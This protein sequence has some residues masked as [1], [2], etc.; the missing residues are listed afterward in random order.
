M[1]VPSFYRSAV[2]SYYGH[3]VCMVYVYICKQDFVLSVTLSVLF[4][5]GCAAAAFASNEANK[6]GSGAVV[7]A[8]IAATVHIYTCL[9]MSVCM[10]VLCVVMV[11]VGGKEVWGSR[12]GGV[13]TLLVP[14]NSF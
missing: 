14:S 12:V 6:E 3:L 10:C 9:C 5:A 11:H 2:C 13:V 8:L 7:S 1:C 4:L